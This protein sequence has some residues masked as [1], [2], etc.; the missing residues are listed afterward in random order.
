M[1]TVAPKNV[2]VSKFRYSEPRP[3]GKQGARTVYVKY[4]GEALTM[5]LPWMSMPYGLNDNSKFA[6]EAGGDD[7]A[8]VKYE[9]NVSFNGHDTNDKMK[10]ALDKMREIEKKVIDDAYENRLTWLKDDYDGMKPLVAKLFSPFIKVDKD[11]ETGKVVGKY[12]PTMKL[13]IPYNTKT[14]S[15][16]FDCVDKNN[17]E[18]DFKDIMKSLKGGRILP[19]IQLS[20]IWMAGGKYGCTW[21]LVGARFETASVT[22]VQFIPVSDDEDEEEEDDIDAVSVEHEAAVAEVTKK[23][24]DTTVAEDTEE[25]EEEE[26]DSEVEEEEEDVPP[27]PPPPKKT[28]KAKTAAKK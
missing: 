21:K 1:T 24:A 9:V 25:E 13:R 15:F 26:V 23:V 19:I 12:P 17:A 8:P 14:D 22:K 5:Q 11:K 10:S 6:K 20:S 3:L 4:N 16:T 2:D 18:L 27:P 7:S 28:T